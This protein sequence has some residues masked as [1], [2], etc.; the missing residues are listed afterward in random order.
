M[1]DQ[2]GL[3]SFIQKMQGTHTAGQANTPSSVNNGNPNTVYN[4]SSYKPTVTEAGGRPSVNFDLI[5]SQAPASSPGYATPFTADPY[6]AMLLAGM[7]QARDSGMVNQI[8]GRMFGG[9]GGSG[10]VGGVGPAPNPGTGGPV[11]PSTP[12]TPPNSG[13]P[14]GP[15]YTPPAG[16]N[17]GG[18]VPV[19]PI[20][21]PINSNPHNWQANYANANN[22][23]MNARGRAAALPWTALPPSQQGPTGDSS[24]DG[25][26]NALTNMWDSLSNLVGDG[27]DY[28]ARDFR[29]TFGDLTGERGGLAALRAA[30]NILQPGAGLLIPRGANE[31]VL[32]Q[33][34]LDAI[35]AKANENLS[36]MLQTIKNNSP[37]TQ[38]QIT[39]KLNESL[40]ASLQRAYNS[41][42]SSAE[43]MYNS[44]SQYSQREWQQLQEHFNFIN[45]FE[46]GR[47]GDIGKQLE[48]E[49]LAKVEATRD[50]WKFIK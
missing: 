39:A 8:L 5:T 50:K 30:A 37:L 32:T 16:S 33:R 36:N 28:L 42:P 13:T 49:A 34:E 20:S 45:M 29:E 3:Q 12:V 6:A 43:Q 18:G 47:A 26:R 46:Q 35:T 24:V 15:S 44:A 17:R 7:P 2:S 1:T 38:E 4:W 23:S 10:S 31:P 19:G 14:T 41:G 25:A 9:R 11:G 40:Q 48:E 22:N 27:V 21:G